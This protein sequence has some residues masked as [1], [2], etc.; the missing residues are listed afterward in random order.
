MRIT[1]L[2]KPA[3][4]AACLAAGPVCAQESAPPPQGAPAAAGNPATSSTSGTPTPDLN[5]LDGLE[6][7]QIV[8]DGLEASPLFEMPPPPLSPMVGA[9]RRV[10]YP[11]YSFT[12]VT[13]P[14][15]SQADLSVR[16]VDEVAR[17][18]APPSFDPLARVPGLPDATDAIV[19][20][21]LGTPQ[22]L[23]GIPPLNPERRALGSL[24]APNF[25]RANRSFLFGGGRLRY[26]IELDGSAAY[27][28]NVFGTAKDPKSDMI[29]TLQPVVYVEGG[30]WNTFR[31]LWAPTLVKYGKY[32]EFDSFNQ[33]FLFSSRFRIT[34]LRLGLDASYITQSGLFLSSVG[35]AQQKTLIAR[36]SASYPL[37]PKTDL[38]ALLETGNVSTEPGGTQLQG[39]FTASVDYRYSPKTSFGA[40]VTTGYLKSDQGTT[41]Y[42]TFLIRLLYTPTSKIVF[43]GDVGIQFRQSKG[44]F[45]S[46][47]TISTA[48]INALLTYRVTG[49]SLASLR[50]FRNVDV[51]AFSPGNLQTLTGV[52][53]TFSTKLSPR[54]VFDI[55]LL[56]GYSQNETLAGSE[57]G[58]YSFVQGTVSLAY[59][60]RED[61]NIR[62]FTSAQQR[63]RDSKDNN[64][65]SSTTGMSLGGRF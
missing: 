29:F 48:V 64:Y 31:F 5:V 34:K 21:I 19:S 50:G 15:F 49:K 40:S 16:A 26:A 59:L 13:P 3:I 8:T 12:G 53:A 20:S 57:S 1:H 51:D 24:N 58:E 62:L 9:Q 63:F 25:L 14:A 46:S 2:F 55:S 52:E 30:K 47:S 61:I 36:I 43:K 11:D 10:S 37:G 44:P 17:D 33:S 65:L 27:G 7:L 56:G 18:T 22:I 42:E 60:L 38:S 54:A 4:A 28:T 32:K 41:T 23:A 39:S 6:S 45:G 35:Q